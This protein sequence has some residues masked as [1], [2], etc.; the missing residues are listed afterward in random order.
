M[1]EL[2]NPRRE[3]F[4]QALAQGRSRSCAYGEAGYVPSRS[5]ASRL[6]ADPQVKA[7][8]IELKGGG[9]EPPSDEPELPASTTVETLLRACW[10]I[11]VRAI[12][13]NEFAVASAT[14]ERAA[15]IAGLWVDRPVGGPATVIYGAQPV[16]AQEWAERFGHG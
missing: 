9:A 2:A 7:R 8:V 1:P 14:I 15:K 10:E 12:R 4:A 11:V 13:E 16:T 3:A 5:G 6:A